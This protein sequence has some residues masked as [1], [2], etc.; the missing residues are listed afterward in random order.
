MQIKIPA[1]QQVQ[2][3][4]RQR[5]QGKS[6]STA[7]SITA[8]GS[9]LVSSAATAQGMK[10]N[11][12]KQQASLFSQKKE[13]MIS[14]ANSGKE[15]YNVDELPSEFVTEGMRI[16]G[17]V[18][19][20]EVFPQMYDAEMEKSINEASLIIEDSSARSDW[21]SS[22]KIIKDT[23]SSG[24]QEKANK[25]ISKQIVND[26]KFNYDNAMSSGDP[27]LAISIA[28]EMNLPGPEKKSIVL[29]AEKRLETDMYSDFMSESDMEG[30][31]QSIANLS[32]GKGYES[33]G[34][35]LNPNEKVLWKHKLMAEKVRIQGTSD[36][37]AV[38][39][40]KMITKEV[41]VV[42]S[43]LLK[44]YA[45]NPDSLMDLADRAQAI[46]TSPALVEDMTSAF[47]FATTNDFQNKNP[48]RE[49]VA[50]MDRLSN[51]AGMPEFRQTQLKDRLLKSHIAQTEAEQSDL[52]KSASDAGFIDLSPLNA[53]DP[54]T[55]ASQLK[56]RFDQMSMV[57]NRYEVFNDKMLTKSEAQSLS[58]VINSL[59]ASKQVP[60]LAAISSALGEDATDFYQQLAL[61]GGATSLAV[62]GITATKGLPSQA[63][64][65][66][67]G[68]E[69]R[70]QNK[71]EVVEVKKSLSLNLN[72]DIGSAFYN[73]PGMQRAIKDATLDAYIYYSL[74]SGNP[75]D[76][77]DSDIFDMA[78]VAS[79][80]GMV[81]Y[82]SQ[83]VQAP[84]YG[85]KSDGL[86]KWIDFVDSSYIDDLGGIDGLKSSTFT[87]ELR[88]G[89][90]K[91]IG[92]GYGK[93]YI[94]RMNGT[95]LKNARDGGAFI[96]KYDSDAKI[97]KRS[98]RRSRRDGG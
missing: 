43:N 33:G 98:T 56:D 87:K 2:S 11:R 96:L 20:A 69:Y 76:S 89:N 94:T 78:L 57:Q 73:S 45:S 84:V 27:S 40:K 53:T 55:F 28:K 88:D 77:F 59:P 4:G 8:L 83:K 42:T 15:F 3:L 49:R 86:S 52:M 9:S 38:A 72:K 17:R 68:N 7:E 18:M 65:I 66:L 5:F 34:G 35:K 70:R 39:A 44:G 67:M 63:E 10:T 6:T 1:R 92:A 26:Q 25:A 95:H 24:I 64:A 80:G 14:E 60:Y 32:D 23:K 16:K 31:D 74:K 37:A 58:G 54:G 41:Q 29:K 50:N 47:I 21:L 22:A 51:Q 13:A 75:L 46:G 97:R 81:S 79:T 82:G 90:F 19:S 62:A 36:A 61:D 85:M 93:Y 91:L 30:I 48:A 12:Q 71:D